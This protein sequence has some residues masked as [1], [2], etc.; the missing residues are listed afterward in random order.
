MKLSIANTA[1]EVQTEV[2]RRL[3][4]NRLNRGWTQAELATRAGV[5]KRSVERL[6]SGKDNPRMAVFLAVV[7]TLG[8]IDRL[9]A[10]LPEVV[11]TPLDI[12]NGKKP[13]QRIRH[14]KRPVVKWGDW[15]EAKA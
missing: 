15:G 8:L 9:D 6:E 2:A 14:G 10:L 7:Q 11:Q 5:S 13:P 12:L 3:T 1:E 4:Q